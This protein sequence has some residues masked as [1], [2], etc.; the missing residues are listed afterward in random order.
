MVC[1][2]TCPDPDPGDDYVPTACAK[3]IYLG[4][5]CRGGDPSAPVDPNACP[6]LVPTGLYKVAVND[7]IAKGGS[8][9]D[10]LKRNTSKQFTTISL[11]DAL[12]DF[13]RQQPICADDVIDTSAPVSL[14]AEERTVRARW[15]EVACIDTTVEPHDGRIRPVFE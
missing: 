1:S 9:F 2:G 10:A 8:G 6:P 4:D 15:G 14:P 5:N 12:V 13:L 3:S 7:Y 11:R